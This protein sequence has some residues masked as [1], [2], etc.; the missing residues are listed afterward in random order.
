MLKSL[1][2]EGVAAALDA[3][4]PAV[5]VA[6]QADVAALLEEVAVLKARLA[7]VEETPAAPKVFTNGATPPPGTLRGQDRAVDG[8]Q[9][10]DVAKA[11][12]L[13]H[14]L[15][16]GTAAEQNDAA[17]QMQEAA[18]AQLSAIHSAPRR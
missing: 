2:A 11:R 15:Y 1:V 3:R 13:K 10:V 12:E 16:K 9:P 8:G 4:S 5:D 7:T 6:K 14:T 17:R 18:I